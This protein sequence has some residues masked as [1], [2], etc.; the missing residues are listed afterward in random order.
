MRVQR[1]ELLDKWNFVKLD[2]SGSESFSPIK[3]S[4]VTHTTAPRGL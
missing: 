4:I 2:Q 3:F 1:Q